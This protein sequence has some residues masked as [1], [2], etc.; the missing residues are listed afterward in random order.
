MQLPN[1]KA[2]LNTDS[3][4]TLK[5]TPESRPPPLE[6]APICTGT[7]QPKAGK[8]LGN[9]FETRKDWLIPPNYTNG[10]SISADNTT[11]P[12]PPIKVESKP[13]ELR[14]NNR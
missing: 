3:Q 13:E 5:P 2:L 14:N 10:S 11:G 7:L 4:K 12:K 8:M 9:L 1:T 6:D